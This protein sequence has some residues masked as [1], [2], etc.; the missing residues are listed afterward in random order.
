MSCSCVRDYDHG[1]RM[2]QVLSSEITLQK[3]V[4]YKAQ[5]KIC[6]HQVGRTLIIFFFFRK[7]GMTGTIVLLGRQ[8]VE[9]KAN[10]I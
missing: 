2:Y 4:Q 7:Q 6:S 8:E 3:A 10:W 5:G 9:N 1:L